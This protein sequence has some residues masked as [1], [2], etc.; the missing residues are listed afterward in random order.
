LGSIALTSIYFLTFIFQS[1]ETLEPL[2][3][4]I[5]N[6]TLVA[7]SMMIY[8]GMFRFYEKTQG[9]QQYVVFS[10]AYII[11][12]SLFYLMG[13]FFIP[14]VFSALSIAVFSALTGR[15]LIRHNLPQIKRF[16]N[17][18]AVTFFI[19][20]G[21]FLIHCLIHL[22][23]PFSLSNAAETMDV[24]LPHFIFITITLWSIGFITFTNQQV[25]NTF[26]EAKGKYDLMFKT[27]PD[28]LIITRLKDGLFIEVNEGFTNLSGYTW[29]EIKGK[30]ALDIDIWFDPAERQRFVILLTESGYVENMEFKF[31]RKNGKPIIGLLSARTFELNKEWHILT[32]IHDITGRKKM[33]E[34]LRENEQKYRFLTE[35]SADVIWHINN[36]YR[37]DYISPADETIRGY[38]REEIIGQ[39][40]WNF[41][42]PAGIKL[43]REK[44]EHHRQDEQDGKKK[45]STRFEIQQKCKDGSWIWTE[46][47]ATPHYNEN[48]ILIGYHGISRDIT[49]RKQLLDELYHQATIDDLTSIPNRRHFMYLAE[50]EMKI[51]KRY[52]HP[53][54]IIVVDFDNLKRINDT[55]GHLAGD[56][57]LSVF[58]RI[59]Q[60]IIREVDILGRFGGDEFLILLPETT[61]EQAYRVMERINQVLKSSPIFYQ[62]E[63]FSLSVS[64]GIASIENWTDT[65]EDLLN[66]ADAALYD[67]KED[68]Q[69]G[70]S[71]NH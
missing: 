13:N 56:R 68:T 20:S 63:S 44:M 27:I 31:R 19:S 53:I 18:I 41:F 33:E 36:G 59:V 2:K 58:S 24:L 43:V 8:I 49:E 69:N 71:T 11:I 51:A 9:W 30:T 29:D 1:I 7:A 45:K 38:K 70:I 57:A 10:A 37:V 60:Q 35:N 50:K 34:K 26:E 47:C 32:V 46:I 54:S 4:V 61:Q 5:Q 3:N 62:D 16:T 66:R 42:N 55:Y 28:A 21:F 25:K 48:G 67:A 15:L 64:S 12:S 40:I 39:P 52:H 22:I 17:V 23:T 6:T 65:L 14:S